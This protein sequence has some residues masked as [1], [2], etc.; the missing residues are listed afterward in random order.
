MNFNIENK[1]SISQIYCSKVI[2][3]WGNE[4]VPFER[5]NTTVCATK[6]NNEIKF[7]KWNGHQG[8]VDHGIEG[9]RSHTISK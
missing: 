6:L 2:S 1:D 7:K 5:W 9:E 4:H 8:N 3:L